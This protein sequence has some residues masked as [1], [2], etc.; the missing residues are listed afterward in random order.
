MWIPAARLDLHAR[1][2]VAAH[3]GAACHRLKLYLEQGLRRAKSLL[4]Q[5]TGDGHS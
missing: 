5:T 3:A 2:C 1:L 4:A